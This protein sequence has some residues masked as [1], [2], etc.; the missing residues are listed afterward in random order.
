MQ[1]AE[2]R[3]RSVLSGGPVLRSSFF[4][5]HSVFA[6]VL[7]FAPPARAQWPNHGGD[8]ARSCIA[9]RAPR[10]LTRLAWT[11]PPAADEEFVA[12]STPAAFGGRVFVLARRFSGPLHVGNRLIAFDAL[13]GERLWETPLAA[14]VLDAWTS[15]AVDARN[16]TV[17]VCADK[18]VYAVRIADG[19][20]EWTRM[21][22]RSVVNASPV[23]TQDLFVNGTPANRVLVSDYTGFAA[24]G[25]LHAIN[26]DPFH[27]VD[28]PHQPGEI[29][30]SAALSGA[31]GNSAAYAAQTV[32]VSSVN[33]VIRAFDA[34]DG[35][36]VW[37]TAV[38]LSGY[39]ALTGFYGGVT[40]RGD[41]LYAALYVFPAGQNNAALYRLDAGDGA[42]V[43]SVACER[44]NSMPFADGQGRV[45][46]S[47]GI[48]GDF[49]S[50]NKVQAFADHGTHA[51]PL[52]DTHV[53]SGGAL[54]VGGWTHQPVY[55][56]GRLFAG[57]P[58]GDTSFGP[59]VELYV[60]DPDTSPGQPGFILSQ[61]AGA[62]GSP[63][64]AHGRLYSLGEDGLVALDP[65][66]ACLA[67]VT[68]DGLVN[69]A[70]LSAL[71]TVYGAS[72][73]DPLY[74]AELDLDLDGVIGLS[75]LSLMLGVF[76]TDCP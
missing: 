29:A 62:G 34:H 42:V 38:D 12:R 9:A 23:V 50:F 26:V 60:L 10:D 25:A 45:Y 76:G 33:G 30:W 70:D 75:D 73:G 66:P 19:G 14:D 16:N 57:R 31:V 71:L 65:S 6:L 72:E 3:M 7:A 44:T 36:P 1:I 4:I 15:P 61:R 49:G 37:Q 13:D 52:W 53:D 56:R 39:P 35:S 47:G 54:E 17:I 68:G 51:T 2:C 46:V 67:D 32:Y 24:G 43:W 21:L 55:S 64:A 18:T 63:A 22:S 20:I 5:L 48:D 69:V 41:A 40:V 59:Y 8:A 58:G 11:A 27:A 28:N 74:D